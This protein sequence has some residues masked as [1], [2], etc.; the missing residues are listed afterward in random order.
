MGLLSSQPMSSVGSLLQH[1]AIDHT[2][3]YECV[4]L[5]YQLEALA[6][7]RIPIMLDHGPFYTARP[8]SGARVQL[9]RQALQ[10]RKTTIDMQ[11]DPSQARVESAFPRIDMMPLLFTYRS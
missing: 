9:T 4:S 8:H 7:K 3:L 5:F 2:V 1:R 6:F 11:A 10:L